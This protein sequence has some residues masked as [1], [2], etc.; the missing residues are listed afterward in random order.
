VPDLPH[1]DQRVVYTHALLAL[2]GANVYAAL[3]DV[4]DYVVSTTA[5][6]ATTKG[7]ASGQLPRTF[8]E[9]AQQCGPPGAGAGAGAGVSGAE[10][11]QQRGPPSWRGFVHGAGG[12]GRG[13]VGGLWC[14]PPERGP[15]RARGV[16]ICTL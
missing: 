15:L 8:P 4:D 13:G 12:G 5:T 14:A 2:T 7:A 9:L 1:F 3:L 11:A 6:S 10:V 16:C